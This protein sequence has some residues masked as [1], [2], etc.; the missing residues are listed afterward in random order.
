MKLYEINKEMTQLIESADPTTGEVDAVAFEALAL[1]KGE[2]QKNIVLFVNHLDSDNEAIE[3]EIE[4]LK[5]MRARSE[6]AKKW[7]LNYLKESMEFDGVTELDFVTFKAKIKKNPPRLDVGE[8][9][10]I[11]EKFW[12]VKTTKELDKD[13]IK[14]AI[15]SGEEVKGCSIA[16]GT[17]LE[18]K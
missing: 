18:I 9:V 6:N 15:K 12:K 10:N 5:V 2:K 8:S 14:E 3:K 16:Q 1:A 11:P 4:R 17:R 13:A 7:L